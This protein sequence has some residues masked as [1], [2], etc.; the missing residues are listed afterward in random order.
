MV[1]EHN[2]GYVYLR[3]VFLSS[4]VSPY[5]YLF[6]CV[7]ELTDSETMLQRRARKWELDKM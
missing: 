5:I 1:Q 2:M 3:W 4:R 6:F 7:V